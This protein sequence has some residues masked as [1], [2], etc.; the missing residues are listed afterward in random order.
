MQYM[1][2]QPERNCVIDGSINV[3]YQSTRLGLHVLHVKY[4]QREIRRV[5]QGVG[6]YLKPLYCTTVLH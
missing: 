3:R 4:N 6:G 1:S 2:I 5:G